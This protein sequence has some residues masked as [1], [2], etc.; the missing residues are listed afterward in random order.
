MNNKGRASGI[1]IAIAAVVVLAGGFAGY[2]FNRPEYK[3]NKAIEAEDIEK[4]AKYYDKMKDSD[5]KEEVEKSMVVY[6]TGLNEQYIEDDIEY[7]ELMDQYEILEDMLDGNDSYEYLVDN[8]KVLKESKEAYENGKK[9]LAA[10]DYPTALEEFN[11][12][13]SDDKNYEKALEQIDEVKKYLLP[14]VIGRWAANIELGKAIAKSANQ[15]M[16][17]DIEFNVTMYMEFI[18]EQT[19]RLYMDPDELKAALKQYVTDVLNEAV[20]VSAKNSGL[21]KEAFEKEFKKMYGMSFNKYIEENMDL[22]SAFGEV[23][24]IYDDFTYEID[25]DKINISY[26][27]GNDIVVDRKDNQLLIGDGSTDVRALGLVKS[28][29]LDFPFVF[30]KE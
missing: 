6:C 24:D 27:S 28:Y 17:S 20:E 19:G 16:F 14:D 10:Q 1:I 2:W 21:S 3:V 23:D 13:S 25:G 18:D 22:E 12:V 7:D 29:G 4:V 5:A 9:A 15:F 8:A 30:E 11:K 26:A